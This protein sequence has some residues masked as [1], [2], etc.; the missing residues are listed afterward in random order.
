MGHVI[1]DNLTDDADM[2]REVRNQFVR[3]NI[4]RRRFYKCSVAVK[5][6]L[7]K[8]YCI[9]LYDAALWSRYNKG[10]LRKLSSWYNKCVKLFFGYKRFDSV[11]SSLDNKIIGHLAVLNCIWCLQL[12]VVLFCTC[13]F[14]LSFVWFMCFMCVWCVYYVFYVYMGQVPEIKPMMMMI[15]ILPNL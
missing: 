5:R 3:T 2:Q 14:Y 11:T 15:I 4:L 9:S 12:L 7:F 8:S 1:T 6:V 13:E 10:S